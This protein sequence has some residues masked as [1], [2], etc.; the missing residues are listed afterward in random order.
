MAL[1]GVPTGGVS[2]P[3]LSLGGVARPVRPEGV[4]LSSSPGVPQE[5]S[6]RA[7]DSGWPLTRE[8][9]GL[10]RFGV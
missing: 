6:Q 3:R 9:S 4:A 5:D 2:E 7:P 1:G 8:D 10:P